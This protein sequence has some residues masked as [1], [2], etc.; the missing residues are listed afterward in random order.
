MPKPEQVLAAGDGVTLDGREYFIKGLRLVDAVTLVIGSMIGSGIFIVSADIARTVSSP[1][2]LLLVWLI[3]GVLT[4]IGAL[5]YAEL[6]AAMPEAGGQYVFLREAFGRLPAFLYGWTLFLVI[7][8][9][10]IAAVAVAFAK[11]AGVLFPAISASNIL[12]KFG[13]VVVSTDRVV[14]M[15]VIILLTII[16]CRGVKEGAFVQNIFTFLKVL[17]LITLLI[18][19]LSIGL[20]PAVIKTNFTNLFAGPLHGFDIWTSVGAAMVGSLFAMDAWAYVCFAAAEVKNPSKNLPRALLFGTGAVVVLYMLVNIGYMCVLPLV[21]DPN[22]ADILARGIQYASSDRVATAVVQAML[23]GSAV[24][25]IAAA[26]MISTFGCVNGNILMCARMYYALAKDRLFFRFVSQINHRT[27]VPTRALILGCIWACG[28][29]LTGSYSELLDY[30]IFATLIFYILTIIGLLVLR[31][32]RPDMKRPYKAW[33]YPWLQ[34]IY[35]V[36]ASV[37]SINL[38]I[39]KPAYT[40]PG[41]IIV[42]TG[43]PVYFIWSRRGK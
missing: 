36:V 32:K 37:V 22:G 33:G 31:K 6:A 1:G 20:D 26:I 27:H 15:G 11:F 23:G 16:N 29:T 9:G 5:S 17:A 25:L 39:F 8:T 12:F 24:M 42:L 18:G 35:I 3:S 7:G 38:L 43:V 4:V 13:P 2:L 14:A 34:V 19:S 10:I 30:V 28:L 41:L 40:W 21:G